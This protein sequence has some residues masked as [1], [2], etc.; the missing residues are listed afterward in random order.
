MLY[1]AVYSMVH[2]NSFLD[3]DYIL[4]DEELEA[5]EMEGQWASPSRSLLDLEEEMELGSQLDRGSEDDKDGRSSTPSHT[6]LL[7]ASHNSCQFGHVQPVCS[8]EQ[9]SERIS[10]QWS[11]QTCS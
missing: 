8:I 3:E 1:L 10:W 11:Q 6:P 5:G 4:A 7:G 9:L 2:P